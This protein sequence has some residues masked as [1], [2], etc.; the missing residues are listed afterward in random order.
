MDIFRALFDDVKIDRDPSNGI[1]DYG[2]IYMKKQITPEHLIE[3]EK[4]LDE[5]GLTKTYETLCDMPDCGHIHVCSFW[6]LMDMATLNLEIL[7]WM[8]HEGYLNV[9]NDLYV[10]KNVLKTFSHMLSLMNSYLYENQPERMRELVEF[11]FSWLSKEIPVELC[12]YTVEYDGCKYSLLYH[13]FWGYDDDVKE[14]YANWYLDLHDQY[15]VP[16][17]TTKDTDLKTLIE[18]HPSGLKILA[19]MQ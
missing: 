10:Q 1:G 9:K 7:S 2:R 8:I 3:V 5:Y 14:K 6:E 4:Y 18:K 16:L 13:I 15:G 11:L 17:P 19:R 12:N